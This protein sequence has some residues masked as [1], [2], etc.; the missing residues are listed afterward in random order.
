MS[1]RNDKQ[2][3]EKKKRKNFEKKEKR[4]IEKRLA[5]NSQ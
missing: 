2:R 3:L 5:K 1:T 4:R